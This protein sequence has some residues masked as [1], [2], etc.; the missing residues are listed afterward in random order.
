MLINSIKAEINLNPQNFLRENFPNINNK[1]KEITME[2]VHQFCTYKETDI[3]LSTNISSLK[4]LV[5]I[6]SLKGM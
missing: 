5:D 6:E 3:V 4:I 1:W 2:N